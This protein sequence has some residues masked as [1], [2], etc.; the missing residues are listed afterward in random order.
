MQPDIPPGTPQDWLSRARGKLA[1]ACSPL[2][3]G[4]YWEDLC[5]MLQQAAELA[6]KA[7][8]LQHGWRFAFT[9]D[10]GQLLDGLERKGIAVP[11]NVQNADQLTLF[12]TQ[13]RY[14]GITPPVTQEHHA[15]AAMIAVA[16]VHWAGTTVEAENGKR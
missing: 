9:H 5:Y 12:A 15:Q 1:V 13:T 6:V 4:G 7:V 8:Y 16:V 11:L 2:P 14:P 3:D 10:L